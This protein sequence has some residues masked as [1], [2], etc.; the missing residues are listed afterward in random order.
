MGDDETMSDRERAPKAL[1]W[2]LLACGGLLGVF[3]A[4]ALLCTLYA[5]WGGK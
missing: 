2:A 1:G 3:F 4:W 5:M